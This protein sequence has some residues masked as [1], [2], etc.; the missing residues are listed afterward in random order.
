MSDPIQR[1]VEVLADLSRRIRA[2]ETAPRAPHTSVQGGSTRWF[3]ENGEPP[4]LFIG[5]LVGT[6]DIGVWVIDADGNRSVFLG[7]TT[8]Q[9]IVFVNEA[10]ELEVRNPDGIGRALW[11]EEGITKSPLVSAAWQ[12]STNT[13]TMDTQ[14]RAEISSGTYTRAWS[15]Y[16]PVQTGM[17]RSSIVVQ[18]GAGVTS[19]DARI[20]ATLVE[21]GA[22]G[23]VQTVHEETGITGAGVFLSGL[24]WTIPDAVRSP[25]SD[26][27]GTLVLLEVEA[28]VTGGAG[29]ALVGPTAGAHNATF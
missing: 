10:G 28:R 22:S 18:L 21:G 26:P 7:T 4:Q 14:G 19:V 20:R 5:D 2:L 6:G 27:I 17:I 9:A 15:A 3:P 23:G 25:A 12:H 1:F 16:L 13:S 8:G 11:I 29:N 24:P